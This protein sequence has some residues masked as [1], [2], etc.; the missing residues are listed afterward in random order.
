MGLIDRDKLHNT[1]DKVADKASQVADKASDFAKDH[2]WDKKAENV[3]EKT[4][5]FVKD[6]NIDKAAGCV[7]G[8]FGTGLRKAGAGMEKLGSN[9]ENS[10]REKSFEKQPDDMFEDETS[11]DEPTS[12]TLGEADASTKTADSKEA[13]EEDA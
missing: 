9:I 2:E 11:S 13:S 5:G 8:A 1:L 12:E 4:T 10:I 6:H 3:K 7:A